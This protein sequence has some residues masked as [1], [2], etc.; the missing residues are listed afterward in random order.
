MNCKK[1]F[2]LIAAAAML[3]ACQNSAPAPAGSS[4]TKI[5][6]NKKA[7]NV[8]AEVND[9]KITLEELDER[10]AGQ[11][12]KAKAQIYE[13]RRTALDGL[14]SE[15]LLENAAK[16]ANKTPDQYL[17]DEIY[18]KIDTPTDEAVKLFYDQR[19][20][21]LGGRSLEE[22][23]SQIVQYLTGAQ[24]GQLQAD[25]GARLKAD[26]TIKTYLEPPR[27]KVAI[28]DGATKGPANAPITIIEFTDYDCPFCRK[29]RATI[30]QVLET[31][32]DKVQ[33]VLRD[34][35]LSFHKDAPKAHEAAHCAG[36]QGK[37]W[38][39]SDILFNKQRSLQ[40]DKLKNYAKD[41]ELDL[42][43]FNTCLDQGTYTE[44][45]AQGSQDGVA[46]GVS[47]TPAFFINGI[48]L[49]GA[50]PFESFKKVIDEELTR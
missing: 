37:Y 45:V 34:F 21:Q 2:G 14:L 18:S 28:G 50:R 22:V 41:L 39:Y 10:A 27:T 11:L 31:Y 43:A 9:R 7:P 40:L 32:G 30:D 15:I 16:A 25:L 12:A 13:V 1:I 35:P 46:A 19:K 4:V 38:E 23:K 5:S 8:V 36:D 26:S 33:Y 42:D 47:G 48:P 29:T 6:N 20:S 24:Q 49:S 17:E 3:A 44:R